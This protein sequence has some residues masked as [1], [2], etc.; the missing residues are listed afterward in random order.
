[1]A[2]AVLLS[3]LRTESRAAVEPVK[4]RAALFSRSSAVAFDRAARLAA[5]AAELQVSPADLEAGLFAD[6]PSERRVLPF[7]DA[8]TTEELAIRSNLAFAQ[9]LL[10]RSVEVRLRMEGQARA[11]VR[12]ARLGGLICTIE[13]GDGV[14]LKLTGPLAI[15]HRTLLYGRALSRV[16]PLLAWCNRFILEADLLL[17]ERALELRLNSPAPIFPSV[18]P[19]RFDSKVEERFAR[20]LSRAAPAWE[21]L[22]EPE[23]VRAGESLI[24]PDFLLRSRLDPNRRVWIEIVGFWTPEYLQR[25]LSSLR[26]AGLSNLI[27]CIDEDLACGGDELPQ[28]TNVVRFRGKIDPRR[29]VEILD[30]HLLAAL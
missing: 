11:V 5:A 13:D 19:R 10:F 23:P 26:K 3:L 25:K 8:L 6:L 18:E 29:V 21:V 4:A 30:S 22:R 9:S 15:F 17:G 27:L 12:Q 16:L 20:E 7:E 1:M 14:A 2:I 24:F 28:G